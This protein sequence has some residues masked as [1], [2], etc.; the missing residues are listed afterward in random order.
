[1]KYLSWF[2]RLAW[3]LVPFLLAQAIWQKTDST[4]ASMLSVVLLVNIGV[5]LLNSVPRNARLDLEP[6]DL[7]VVLESAGDRS[8]DVRIALHELLD[9]DISGAMAMTVHVPVN[10]CTRVSAKSADKLAARLTALGANISV[11]PAPTPQ[12]AAS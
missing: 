8:A 12:A 10:I 1:M 5:F 3:R 9:L 2:K 7:D 11:R 6:G 4:I